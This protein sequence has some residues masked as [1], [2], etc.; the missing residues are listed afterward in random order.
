MALS[1][2]NPNRLFGFEEFFPP[3]P[4][5]RDPFDDW[6]PVIQNFDRGIDDMLIRRSSPGYEINESDDK[7]QIALDVPGIK[8]SDITAQ[9]E[10]DGRVL[11]VSGGRKMTKDGVTSETKFEKRFTVGRNVDTTKVSANLSDGV[12]TVT[13]PKV[14]KEEPETMKIEITEN[15]AIE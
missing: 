12:L 15:K 8:A 2:F 9:L 5:V 6:M 3:S 13:A 11:H 4:F 14:K 1:R 10:N 7:F